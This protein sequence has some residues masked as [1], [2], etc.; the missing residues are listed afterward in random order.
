MPMR[1]PHIFLIIFT[2]YVFQGVLLAQIEREGHHGPARLLHS[3]GRAD[4]RQVLR[5]GLRAGRL[6]GAPGAR[7]VLMC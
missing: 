3:A 5:R 7:P 6:A 1:S 2:I 4:Q